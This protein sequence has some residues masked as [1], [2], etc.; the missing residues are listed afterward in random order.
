MDTN[1]RTDSKSREQT[2]FINQSLELISQDDSVDT[3]I[4]AHHPSCSFSSILKNQTISLKD[5]DVILE[6]G[7]RKT[8]DLLKKSNKK[9]IVVLDNPTIPFSPKKC[10]DRKLPFITLN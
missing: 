5:G 10:I 9:I 2:Q 6:N 3:V 7:M 4:L 8:F 1:F